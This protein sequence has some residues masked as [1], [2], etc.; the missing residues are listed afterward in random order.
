MRDC[1]SSCHP[2]VSAA[3]FALVLAFTVTSFH[4]VLLAAA[5]AA[6]LAWSAQAG[7]GWRP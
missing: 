5:L 6:G 7:R 3:W 1:L 2:A 4:P